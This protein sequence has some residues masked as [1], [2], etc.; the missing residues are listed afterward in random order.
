MQDD[1]EDIPV[2]SGSQHQV[3]IVCIDSWP[4][5]DPL[6]RSNIRGGYPR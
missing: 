6:L 2:A 5:T 1:D 3:T 4:L